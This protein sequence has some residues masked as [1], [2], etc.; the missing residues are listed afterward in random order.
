MPL[1]PTGSIDD[2]AGPPSAWL[3]IGDRAIEGTLG[4]H[5]TIDVAPTEEF[6][7]AVAT[8]QIPVGAA[9]TLVIGSGPLEHVSVGL[10][11]WSGEPARRHGAQ[12]DPAAPT[13]VRLDPLPLGADQLL[14]MFVRFGYPNGGDASYLWHVTSG[15]AATATPSIAQAALPPKTPHNVTRSGEIQG[16]IGRRYS[17]YCT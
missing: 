7:N 1:A 16:L 14:H 5:G 6:M 12:P 3:I 2:P 17:M 8:A 15:A 10:R 9:P 4:R 11:P 13:T